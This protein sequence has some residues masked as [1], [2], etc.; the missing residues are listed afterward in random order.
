MPELNELVNDFRGASP[1]QDGAVEPVPFWLRPAITQGQL[2]V[3]R[4][5]LASLEAENA[6]LKQELSQISAGR[7]LHPGAWERMLSGKFCLVVPIDEPYFPGVY[8]LYRAREREMGRWVE[9]DQVIM[10]EAL[11]EHAHSRGED[12]GRETR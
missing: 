4:S 5:R 3:M 2:M 9:W 8:A 12:D 11:S 6:Q 1:E 10:N 7:A